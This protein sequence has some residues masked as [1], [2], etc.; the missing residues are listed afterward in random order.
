MQ[1]SVIRISVSIFEIQISLTTRHLCADVQTCAIRIFRKA[2]F[3]MV[4][5]THKSNQEIIPAF[6]DEHMKYTVH[7]NSNLQASYVNNYSL[8]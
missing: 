1:T 5:L 2:A 6:Y 3:L 8:F 7:G 4:G